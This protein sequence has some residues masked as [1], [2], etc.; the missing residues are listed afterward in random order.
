MRTISGLDV[1]TG[2][3]SV[4]GGS[5]Y[6]TAGPSSVAGLSVGAPPAQAPAVCYVASAPVTTHCTDAQVSALM[7]GSAVIVDNVVV[8]PAP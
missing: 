1:A 3:E 6:S 7:N 5:E 2:T 4:V 8:S